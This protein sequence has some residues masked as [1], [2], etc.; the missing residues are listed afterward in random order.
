MNKK[1]VPRYLEKAITDVCFKHAKMAFVSG[2]RQCGKTTMAKQL[3]KQR[4]A[5]CYYNW[6]ETAFRRLWT[7]DPKSLLQGSLGQSSAKPLLVLDEIHKARLWKRSIKGLYDTDDGEYDIIVTGSARL[8]VYRKGGDSLL[9][10][11]Y[12]FRLHPFTLAELLELTAEIKHEDLFNYLL[13]ASSKYQ[14]KQQQYFNLL[15]KFGPFPEPLFTQDH[16]ILNLWHR[17]RIEKIIHED[18]RDLSRLPELSQIDMLVSLLPE[19]AANILSLRSLSEDL[20]VAYTTVNRWLNYLYELYYAFK[21]QPY[22]QSLP[23]SIKKE[24]KFYLW[25]WSEITNEAAR[26]ENIIAVHLLKYCNYLSDTGAG[27]FQLYYLRNRQQKEIDFLIV[28]DHKPWLPL[29]VKLHDEK[30]SDNWSV[31]MKYLSCEYAIQVVKSPNVYR[32]ESTNFGKII[33]ISAGQLLSCLV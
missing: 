18:L 26:F 3:L 16:K 28:K 32:I 17:G 12:H 21:I 9:G 2:P 4:R 29:E 19:R 7:K 14:P 8:N 31:F 15:D 13:S 22:F 23:R 5:G 20:E 33:V 25:D 27:D 11:Y 24:S 10:R 1:F 30:L 6:D